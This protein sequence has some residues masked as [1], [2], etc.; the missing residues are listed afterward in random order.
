VSDFLASS[1]MQDLAVNLAASLV[2]FGGGYLI[3]KWRGRRPRIGRNLEQ[4]E[5]YPGR[6]ASSARSPST[7]R[8]AGNAAAG[9][10]SSP[11]SNH[12]RSLS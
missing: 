2:L 6:S 9:C 4:H 1:W 12:R 10:A 5:F 8:P 3:G 7:S 11:A